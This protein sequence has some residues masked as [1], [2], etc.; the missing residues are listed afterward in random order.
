MT[1]ISAEHKQ[2]AE[3][4]VIKHQAFI[5]GQYVPAQ[6]GKTFDC[7]SPIDGKV[8]T[9]IA[10]CDQ[11][12]VDIA[13]KNARQTFNQGTWS[14]LNRGER[15]RILLKFAD[16]L[17][18]HA[19]ELALLET[20]DMGKPIHDSSEG[21]IPGA[22]SKIRWVAECIDKV[23]DEIAPTNNDVLAMVTRE[24]CGVV[25][26]V[27]P[28]N[29]PFYLAC[30]KI[31]P[32][33]AVGNSIIL[34]PAEQSPLSALRMAELAV[35]AGIPKG[36]INVLPGFGET[37][38][39]ALGL[40][41]DV[42]VISF[43]G[44]TEVGKFFLKYSAQSN[45]KRVYLECGG[46]SPNIILGDALNLEEAARA[47][48]I[49][50]F[51]NQGQICCAPT[52]LLVQKNVKDQVIETIVELSKNYQPNDPLDPDTKMGAIVNQVQMQRILE[53]IEAGNTS[54]AKLKTGGQQARKNSGGFYIEPT[55][56]AQVNN[57]MK[58][59]R[60]EIFGP[61]LSVISFDTIEEAIQ[62]AN[63]THYGL[64]ANL[65]TKN[66]NTAHKISRALRAG[67]ISV[68]CINSGDNTTPFGGYKQ[69]GIGREGGIH[70][71]D[72]FCEIKTTWIALGG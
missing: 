43:T 46:K 34:K 40:H 71:F 2:Q 55:V 9:Q 56:F 25:A 51:H 57:D 45:M 26:A 50:A 30:A 23:Y 66:I 36:V 49:G 41:P 54:G 4:L 38:G 62:I 67:V 12:D 65:W 58:I 39:A 6:S 72:E 32:A 60:E 31:A 17:E 28:W 59:A 44:S 19:Y 52:R 13:V 16:I 24:P 53:Y 69:S 8:L 20:M 22:I 10:S 47:S 29:F 64:A 7:I 61:V 68:N 14:K 48:A 18:K 5:N 3:Q 11:A 70:Q 15:K 63:D 21:D 33:I 1:T 42:D 37:A 27:T 35:E